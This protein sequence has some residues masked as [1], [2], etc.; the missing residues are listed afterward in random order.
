MDLSN[1]NKKYNKFLYEF[2]HDVWNFIV[3]E[4]KLSLFL[5]ETYY[6]KK[7]FKQV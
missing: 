1:N 3:Q 4:L 6:I 7:I 2:Q 5:L